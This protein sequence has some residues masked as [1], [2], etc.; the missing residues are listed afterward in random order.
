MLS[1]YLVLLLAAIAILGG[2]VVVAMGRGG[3][4]AVF[5]ND[6]PIFVARFRTPADIASLRLPLGPVGYRVQP[7]TEAL[8]AAAVAVAE[9]DAEIA[10]LR[11]EV[12]RLTSGEP[13]PL[14][15]AELAALVE[16][17]ALVQPGAL[18]EPVAL[19]EPGALAEPDGLDEAAEVAEL[20]EQGQS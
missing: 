8:H 15:R 9:R 5:S 4:L 3:E 18:V 11:R 2:V 13:E 12:L 7:T 14:G 20:D 17:V 1:V 16:P 10:Q 6:R 19:V